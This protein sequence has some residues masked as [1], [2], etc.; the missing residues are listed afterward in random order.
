MTQHRIYV[1]MRPGDPVWVS[2]EELL[3]L[4]RMGVFA[5]LAPYTLDDVPPP[6]PPVLRADDPSTDTRQEEENDGEEDDGQR[7]A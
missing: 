3:D 4:T 1:T 6:L 5:G 2:D 7:E